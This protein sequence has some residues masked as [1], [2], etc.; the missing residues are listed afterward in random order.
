[1]RRNWLPKS[2]IILAII[3]WSIAVVWPVSPEAQAQ[4]AVAEPGLTISGFVRDEAGPLAGAVVRI[5]STHYKTV[6]G[7]DGA[8]VLTG[9][10]T[11][12]PV[13]VTVAAQGYFQNWADVTAGQQ[14]VVITLKAH[15]TSD[16]PEYAWQSADNCGECHTAYHEWQADAHAQAAVNPR[17]ITMYKGTDVHGNQSPLSGYSTGWPKLP[18]LSQP[19]FGPGFKI[20]FPDRDGNCASCHTPMASSLPTDNSCG[21]SGCH[22]DITAEYS[23]EIPESVTPT[24][25]TGVAAEGISCDF[26]HKVGEVLL[27][28]ETGL[29]D[30]ELTG[31]MSMRL[32]RPEE[33]EELLFGS[34]DDVAREADSFMPMHQ[35]SAFCAP[36]HYGVFN[37]K[38]VVIYGS[39]AEW[40]AS[41]YSNPET[42]QTCQECH[43]PP[44]E[45]GN[46][47]FPEDRPEAEKAYF[48]FHH[49]GGVPRQ[50]DRIH[51]HQMRGAAD[52]A[53]LQNSVT[54]TTTA[55][56]VEGELQIS[57][58]ITNDKTGH[59]VPTDS[60]L[61][62]LIL[63]V[64]AS[65]AD[66]NPLP[67]ED[68]PVLPEWAGN[69]AEQ[70]G[71][72]YAKILEDENTKEMPAFNFW[73]YVRVV[74]DTRIAAMATDTSQYRFAAPTEG[75]ITVKAQLIYRRAFQQLMAWKGWNDPDI[76]MEEETITLS[77]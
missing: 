74:S 7:D 63:V 55:E 15:F 59:H 6:S 48:V 23:E 20:D 46:P 14:D 45:A 77:R 16:N 49:Q 52:Q 28:P 17:F 18:D 51:N 21:W 4:E 35:E 50:P 11:T 30:P 60:P 68:G 25:L 34:V 61:R 29:P 56:L 38:E 70:P 5:Q 12:N 19:Y 58:S 64:Q 2:I 62:H 53:L 22:K 71:Q 57:V 42:G 36:C 1:M 44:V 33:G 40:L 54:M 32:F 8:F 75:P 65:D 73:A 67:L 9:V 47:L 72:L 31:I 24:D 66:G 27:K 43:M 13:R 41:P 10:S 26:C 3:S 39:Y 69:Y 37:N 76:M